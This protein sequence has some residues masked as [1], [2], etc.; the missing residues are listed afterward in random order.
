MP[1]PLFVFRERRH[2]EEA[3]WETS[4]PASKR[5]TEEDIDAF[6]GGLLPLALTAL[7]GR[8][9]TNDAATVLGRLATLR[10]QL[11]LTKFLDL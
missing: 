5:L 1:L 10:T 8:S 9:G 6:V 2:H 7:F 4:I 3:T 11:V